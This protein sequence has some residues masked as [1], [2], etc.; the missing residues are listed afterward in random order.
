MLHR[1]RARRMTGK[2]VSVST[3]L[4]SNLLSIRNAQAALSAP[5]SHGVS[6]DPIS[7]SIYKLSTILCLPER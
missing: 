4:F 1:L 7:I 3:D 6:S 5:P 2:E